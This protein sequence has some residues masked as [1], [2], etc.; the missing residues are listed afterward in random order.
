V[1]VVDIF[2]IR[3]PEIYHSAAAAAATKIFLLLQ[4]MLSQ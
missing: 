3:N 1:V 2:F 4:T